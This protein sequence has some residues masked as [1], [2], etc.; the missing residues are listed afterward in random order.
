MHPQPMTPVGYSGL[1]NPACVSGYTNSREKLRDRPVQTG[2]VR[3]GQTDSNG[4]MDLSQVLGVP[5]Q[6]SLSEH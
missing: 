5:A 6:H 1:A 3:P 4:I 2:W